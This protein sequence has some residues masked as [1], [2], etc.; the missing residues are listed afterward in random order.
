MQ[1]QAVIKHFTYYFRQM[2]KFYELKVPR[3]PQV[4]FILLLAV[5]FGIRVLVQPLI[6]ELNIYYQQFLTAYSDFNSAPE[7]VDAFMK[8]ML[9][10]EYKQFVE[11]TLKVLGIVAIQYALT[12]LLSFFYL[13]AY[14]VDLEAREVSFAVYMKKFLAA[15]PRFIG[16]QV[17]FH[18]GIGIL[19]LLFSVFI[20]LLILILPL[21]YIVVIFLP[22]AWLVIEVIFIFKEITLLD[23]GVGIFKNFA[24]SWKLSAGNRFMIGRNIFFIVILNMLANMLVVGS[25]ILLSLF[26]ISFIEVIVLLIKQRLIALMYISRTRIEKDNNAIKHEED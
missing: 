24:L 13:G 2:M 18:I 1:R 16:F 7:N 9:S 11:T 15:L 14:L 5:L 17:L 19:G 21:M 8:F 23:T 10:E 26:I 6:V 3:V 20:S 22:F 25:N 12:I 4:L